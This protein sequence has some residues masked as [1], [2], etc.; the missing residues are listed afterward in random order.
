[1][2]AATFGS[3]GVVSLWRG[4]GQSGVVF[5]DLFGGCGI[6]AIVGGFVRTDRLLGDLGVGFLG[7]FGCGGRDTT[8]LVTD[9]R[10]GTFAVVEAGGA[11]DATTGLAD[12][13]GF[14][15]VGVFLAGGGCWDAADLAACAVFAG[16]SGWAR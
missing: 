13:G 7:D 12:G 3:D 5:C 6:W 15:T 1:M 10:G 8:A 2:T 11:R 14:C 16:V 9:Q 4:I